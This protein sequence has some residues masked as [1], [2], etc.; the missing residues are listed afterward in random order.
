[1]KSLNLAS[2]DTS[3]ALAYAWEL[4][5]V[6][7]LVLAAPF[8]MDLWLSLPIAPVDLET[9]CLALICTFTIL[10]VAW[11]VLCI[12]FA[13]LATLPRLPRQ[14]QRFLI[15]L[16]QRWGTSHA[17]SVLRQRIARSALS[18]SLISGAAIP[19]AVAA[20]LPNPI[21]PDLHSSS[22]VSSAQQHSDLSPSIG[23]SSPSEPSPASPFSPSPSTSPTPT[24]S[25][26]LPRPQ[27]DRPH[28]PSL[29]LPSPSSTTK[30]MPSSYVVRPGDCLWTIAE[31]FHPHADAALLSRLTDELYSANA[32]TI[33]DNPDLIFP[34]T[35]LTLPSSIKEQP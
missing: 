24:V 10:I 35:V 17:Q 3:R 16:V 6:G 22:P 5:L 27:I 20:H 13:Y 30:H 21:H 7:I 29:R 34:G 9:L 26:P 15:S 1:M 4:T 33:G 25:F 12:T 14:I 2:K 18:I 19:S 8:C 31:S 32:S 28:T 23:G 11:N